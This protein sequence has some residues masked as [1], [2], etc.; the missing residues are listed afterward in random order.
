MENLQNRL[1]D[2]TPHAQ[3][4]NT[5][6]STINLSAAFIGGGRF[7]SFTLLS[8]VV[9]AEDLNTLLGRFMG[10][11]SSAAARD[12]CSAM[13]CCSLC[14]PETVTRSFF[15][16]ASYFDIWG[17]GG[18]FLFHMLGLETQMHLEPHLCCCYC[19]CCY[20]CC[21]CQAIGD[22]EWWWPPNT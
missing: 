17:G 20:C 6:P 21:G 8:E 3:L 10:L 12:I 16:D 9:C 1:I 7:F 22:G 15:K 13:S 18:H 19:H 5:A 11:S 14:S 4:F 2:T